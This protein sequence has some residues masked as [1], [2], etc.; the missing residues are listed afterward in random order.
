[1]SLEHLTA[2]VAKL[3]FQWK[4]FQIQQRRQFFGICFCS[5]GCYAFTSFYV[6]GGVQQMRGCKVITN[7]T[8]TLKKDK[9]R[10]IVK[11]DLINSI[12]L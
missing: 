11:L 10:N 1:M 7:Y 12:V 5:V 3:A 9:W 4:S 2:C 8:K 6:C